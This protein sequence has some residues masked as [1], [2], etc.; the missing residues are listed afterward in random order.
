M[1]DIIKNTK[2]RFNPELFKKQGGK[3]S[4][5]LKVQVI[6]TAWLAVPEIEKIE[7][8]SVD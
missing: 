8:V 2:F 6:T 3:W 5:E 7:N 4:A 1:Y